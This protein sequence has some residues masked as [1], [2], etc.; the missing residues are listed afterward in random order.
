V[1]AYLR[2]GREFIE[3]VTYY[4]QVLPKGGAQK[5]VMDLKYHGK[6]HGNMMDH[7]YLWNCP[8]KYTIDRYDHGSIL[9]NTYSIRSFRGMKWDPFL[10]AILM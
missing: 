4:S 6:Y 9:I 7:P 10:P 8:W 1:G 2:G 5:G 3:W